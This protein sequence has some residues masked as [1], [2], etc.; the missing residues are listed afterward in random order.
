MNFTNAIKSYVRRWLDFKTRSSRSEYW[1]PVLLVAIFEFFS[2][3]AI[4]SSIGLYIFIPILI[5]SILMT[6]AS[7]AVSVRRLHD[8]DMSGWWILIAFTIIGILL[9]VYWYCLSGTPGDNKYGRDP[10][11]KNV[12]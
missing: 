4:E 12:E 2:R 6:I 8:L 11:E 9:L 10:L 3:F 1:W 7:T 5:V